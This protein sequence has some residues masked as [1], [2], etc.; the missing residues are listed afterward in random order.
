MGNIRLEQAI[1]HRHGEV[2][3][4]VPNIPGD[5]GDSKMFNN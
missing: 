5:G 1:S 3:R 2:Q 4:F